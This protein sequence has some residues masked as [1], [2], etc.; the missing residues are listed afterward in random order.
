M[1]NIFF[2]C[3]FITFVGC[4]KQNIATDASLLGKSK[5]S[6]TKNNVLKINFMRGFPEEIVGCSCYFS[7]TK[8]N[9][10]SNAEKLYYIDDFGKIAFM[11]I[12][13]NL[14]KFNITKTD[15][16]TEKKHSYFENNKYKGEIK[17]LIIPSESYKN[18]GNELW[19]YKGFIEITD[20]KTM[21][22]TK[23]TIYGECGC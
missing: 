12:N 6:T 17:A 20:K 21:Q 1:K 5:N 16:I 9:I 4:K 3:L 2:C 10:Y 19:F 11:K 15:S 14:E 23:V 13:G 22:K 18:E 8:E 7:D